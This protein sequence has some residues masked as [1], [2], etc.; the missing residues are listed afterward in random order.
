MNQNYALDEEVKKW[1]VVEE[2]GKEQAESENQTSDD[3]DNKFLA[4]KLFCLVS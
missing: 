3:D 4:A 2:R 1:T